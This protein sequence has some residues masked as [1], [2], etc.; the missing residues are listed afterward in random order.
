[1]PE[2]ANLELRVEDG[3]QLVPY[4]DGESL[5]DSAAL[6]KRTKAGG[7]PRAYRGK[8]HAGLH[9]ESLTSDLREFR[10]CSVVRD[11]PVLGC[12]CGDTYCD[13]VFATLSKDESTITWELPGRLVVEFDRQ[14]YDDALWKAVTEIERR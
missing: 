9:V 12:E 10:P 13:P 3:W 7:P 1:M 2:R 6:G 5:L 4:I 14:Q 8:G 11:I